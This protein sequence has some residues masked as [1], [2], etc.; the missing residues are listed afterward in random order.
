VARLLAAAL[1][2]APACAA[3]PRADLR[4]RLAEAQKAKDEAAVKKLAAE[5]RDALG[6]KAGVPEVDDVYTPAPA[7]VDP[8]TP[9]ERKAAFDPYLK[10]LPAA[11]WWKVGLDPAKTEHLPRE[12]AEVVGGLLAA[13]RAGCDG[14]DALLA[15]AREAGDYLLWTQKEAGGT[16]VIP[17]PAFRGG[18]G[19]AFEAAERFL[20]QAE[21]AGKLK[22][23]LRGGWAVD[24]L[25]D[26]GLQ[27]DN[28]MCGVALFEL[29]AATKDEKY[30]T[31]ARAVADWAAGR[32][33][34]PNW[35]YNAFSV[36]L[37]ATAH[38]ATGNA[39]YLS[40]AKEKARLGVYPGQL[41]DGDRAGRWADGHNARP[42]YHYILV[43]ALAA[44]LAELPAD[45]PDRP[46]CRDGLRLALKARNPEF[47][48]R[49]VMNKDT[50]LS[51]LLVLLDRLPPAAVE[52]E[53]AGCDIDSAVGVLGRLATAEFRRGK[54]SLGP[55]AW[56]RFLEHAARGQ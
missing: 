25:D 19:A 28:G 38:R 56:G 6:A 2:C 29:Y 51:A 35:N 30:L 14:R 7:K 12:A 54:F 40:A 31:G 9:A 44:L 48:A 3:D 26:G 22:E 36:Y 33:C 34:V 49:G 10:R 50:A 45:D 5:G 47:A 24:D 4:A 53:L 13:A 8:L 21:K 39:K 41:P 43:R 42:A 32:A 37:L 46:A 55:S 18:K 27:F 20:K 23:V 52:K 15:E 1:L 16:G 11:K 17:F